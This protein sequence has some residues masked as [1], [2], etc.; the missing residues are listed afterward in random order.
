MLE[1]KICNYKIKKKRIVIKTEPLNNLYHH[2]KK[3]VI[4]IL[5]FK[6]KI[7]LKNQWKNKSKKKLNLKKSMG[8]SFQP[9]IKKKIILIKE[10]LRD[11][12]LLL[13]RILLNK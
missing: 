1:H 3:S 12:S 6:H 4:K 7:T 5:E 11:T 8:V 10:N 9:K 13:I 2:K